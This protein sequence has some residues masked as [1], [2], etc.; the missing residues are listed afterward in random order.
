MYFLLRRT[1]FLLSAFANFGCFPF[2]FVLI[3]VRVKL[4][5]GGGGCTYQVC[6]LILLNLIFVGRQVGEGREEVEKGTYTYRG[7]EERA[8]VRGEYM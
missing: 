3:L 4:A 8:Y 6:V 2:P 5:D 1:T 7:G